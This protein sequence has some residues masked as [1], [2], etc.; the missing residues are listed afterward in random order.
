VP[1][2]RCV[3]QYH[4]NMSDQFQ[5]IFWCYKFSLS[6]AR[7]C[8]YCACPITAV[9][10]KKERPYSAATGNQSFLHSPAL[11]LLLLL[12]SLHCFT[13]LHAQVPLL[14]QTQDLRATHE[15]RIGID[16]FVGQVVR[17]KK[18]GY[19]AVVLDW[20]RRPQPHVAP[21][22]QKWEAVQSTPR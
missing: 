19:R 11:H 8:R 5:T 6:Q 15:S 22:L 10:L 21:E 4:A 20:H 13:G 1:A 12:L 3:S 2:S 16:F 14:L 9:S 18:Y 7:C 17:H